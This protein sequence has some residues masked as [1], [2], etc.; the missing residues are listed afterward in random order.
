[1]IHE[2][3]TTG[4]RLLDGFKAD[5]GQ[6]TVI[7]GANATGKSSLLECLNVLAWS[8]DYPLENVFGGRL[9]ITSLL[10]ASSQ[11]KQLKWKLTFS[12]PEKV[13]ARHATADESGHKYVYEVKLSNDLYGQPVPEYECLRKAEPHKGDTSPLILLEATPNHSK[14]YNHKQ[15]KL[16]PFDEAVPP[17]KNGGQPPQTPAE[18]QQAEPPRPVGRPLRLGQMRFLNEYPE[19]SQIRQYLSWFAFYPGFDVTMRSPLRSKAA[20]IRPMTMLEPNGDNL[21]TVLHE[22]LTRSFYQDSAEELR[23]FVKLAYP[24]IENIFAETTYGAPPQV[25]VTIREKGMRRPMQLWDLSDGMLRF[26]CLAAALLN[27][28]PPFVTF[29]DEPEV[30]LHPRLLPI[31]GDMIKS[32][33][34]DRQVIV[35]THSPDLL[36]RFDLNDVAVMVREDSCVRWHRP[37]SRPS[38]RTLLESVTGESLGDLHR[39]GELETVA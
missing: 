17:A 37:S 2:L 21:G 24:S 6:M 23:E 8:V 12:I 13:K 5:F 35:T 9:G 30:G 36:N 26:L 4:Y 39:S 31:V 14:I 16:V 25:L 18:D 20:E 7:I 3:E 11:A 10:N 32:A 28:A 34:E 29:A 38:L 22:M 1:M 15:R 27:P 33:A 19:P